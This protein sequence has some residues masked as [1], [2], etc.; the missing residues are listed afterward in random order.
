MNIVDLLYLPICQ[1]TYL[2]NYLPTCFIYVYVRPSVRPSS[3]CQ[4]ACPPACLYI[5]RLYVNCFAIKGYRTNVD[6]DHVAHTH[7]YERRMKISD[8]FTCLSSHI[9]ICIVLAV[10]FRYLESFT[11]SQCMRGLEMETCIYVVVTSWSVDS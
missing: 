11:I 2:S 3:V 7:T 4:V 6:S 8:H 10:A 5:H 1:P 9:D